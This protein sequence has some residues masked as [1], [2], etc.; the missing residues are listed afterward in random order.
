MGRIMA[1]SALGVLMAGCATFTECAE[2]PLDDV[3]I[4]FLSTSQAFAHGPIVRREGKPSVAEEV[5]RTLTDDLT[6]TKDASLINAE[7]LKKY[8]LVVF[9]TQGDLTKSN[10]EGAPPMGENGVTDLIAWIKNGGGFVGFHSATDT[11]RSEGPENTPFSAMI[12][13]EF[14]GHGS[15]FEGVIRVVDA[16]HP[17]MAHVPDGWKLNEEWYTFHKFTKD[18]LHV[19]ALMD[20]GE[21]RAKQAMYNTPA[22][23]VIWCSTLGK[24]RVYYSALG[25]REDI[26]TNPVFQ[27]TVI[28]A[29]R[30]AAGQGPAQAQPNFHEVVPTGK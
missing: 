22:Y 6:V 28:D 3:N 4:L 9:Y 16:S 5:L 19:L 7:N 12:G 10:K 15:Q 14:A 29:F 26:W 30:W 18:T 17:T 23:P 21:E 20:P 13:A 8:D 1:V 27:Q 24:G 25:H 2:E 11:F